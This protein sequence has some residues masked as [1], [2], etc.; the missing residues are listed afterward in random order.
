[1]IVN[2]DEQTLEDIMEEINNI[3]N[4]LGDKIAQKNADLAEEEKRFQREATAVLDSG[5]TSGVAAV[6][7][8]KAM[9]ATGEKIRKSV[10]S[11]QRTQSKS[12]RQTTTGS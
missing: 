6:K 10:H 2:K 12:N 5:A 4:D 1:M 11:T 7:D 3:G 9:I 8:T